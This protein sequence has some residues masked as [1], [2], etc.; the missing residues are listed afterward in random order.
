MRRLDEILKRLQ[1][2]RGRFPAA[3]G[4][5]SVTEPE[6]EEPACALCGDAGFVRRSVPL[7]HPDFGK[8]FPCQCVLDE[9]EEERL[10]RLQ[11]YSNLGSLT[12]LTFENLM[13]KGRSLDPS[14][15][16]R[17]EQAVQAAKEFA[18]SP[19]GWLVFW[20]PSGC[21][22]THLVAA[23]ANRC[24]ER[25]YPAF[26][27]VVADLLDRLRAAYSPESDLPY[28]ELFEQVR[29][30][31][32]VILDDLGS[33]SST[34]WAQ[35]KLFQL[36]NHRYNLQLPTVFTLGVPLDDLDERLRTRLGDASL[37]RTFLLEQSSEGRTGA[38]GG[39]TLPVIRGMTFES[40]HLGGVG[41]PADAERSLRNAFR[42][43][44]NYAESPDGW[45]VLLGRT[46][47]GKT[48]LSASV[49]HY[50]EAK[51]YAVEFCVVPDLLEMLRSAFRDDSATGHFD[52]VF[53]AVRTAPVLILDDLGVHSAT[54]WAQ[55]KL[56]Q[57]LN[58]R[59]NAKLPTVITVGCPLEELPESWVSRM[60][61]DKV[62]MIFE[63]EAPDYR[64][65]P[66]RQARPEPSGRGRPRKGR[67]TN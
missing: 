58:F 46:G 26:F 21:G 50:L 15:Q 28:D 1:E 36:I 47:C 35:E 61:D 27:V 32:L 43:A 40:F 8:A 49:G 3:T 9:A 52:Q 45:L 2:E 62:G 29:N 54:A 23:V 17:F 20:G 7:E 39:L 66:R 67:Y 5:S 24:L 56:F 14:N 31:P 6:A 38:F 11:R 59:Y 48:H 19:G 13:A 41:L 60:Y 42:A 18:E 25:G 34:P 10:R 30:A 65:L 57:I 55:E 37:A 4:S 51:G 33:H 12:R 63:I 44:R 16:Q 53:E 64:G 22:K